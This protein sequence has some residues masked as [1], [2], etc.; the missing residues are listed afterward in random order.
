MPASAFSASAHE[1]GRSCTCALT[2][3]ALSS[4][5]ASTLSCVGDACA[6]AAVVVVSK[7]PAAGSADHETTTR[8]G[9]PSA[10]GRSPVALVELASS[11]SAGCA[12]ASIPERSSDPV[13]P[14]MSSV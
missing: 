14:T 7:Q 12:F 2:G 13:V 10:H 11:T 9:T 1:G 6:Q 5:V 4:L 3:G 8:G